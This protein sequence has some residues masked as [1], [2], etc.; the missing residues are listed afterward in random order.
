MAELGRDLPGGLIG[1]PFMFL[2]DK[3]FVV[4]GGRR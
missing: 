1:A 3:A 2:G 4:S